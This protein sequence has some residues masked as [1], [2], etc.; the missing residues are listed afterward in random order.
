V[1]EKVRRIHDIIGFLNLGSAADG[2]GVSGSDASATN[3]E[4]TFNDD[5]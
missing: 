5:H 3:V 1:E 2:M 4:V